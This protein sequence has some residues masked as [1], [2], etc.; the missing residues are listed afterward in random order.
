MNISDN[1][2][3]IPGIKRLISFLGIDKAIFYTIIGILW[4]SIAGVLSI[5]FIVNYL[6]LSEQGYWY[7]F[8]SLG[9]LGTF[10]ELG[11]TTI[12]TQFISHEYAH[13][14]E[15]KG[16]LFG[17]TK[18]LD[19]TISLI[20]FSFK[21]YLVITIVAFILLSIIGI[22]FLKSTTNNFLLLSSWVLYS[23]TGACF[24]LT[25]LFGAV[26]KGFNKVSTTQKIITITRFFSSIAIWTSLF[27]GLSLWAL[28]IGG[29]VNIIFSL[30]LFFLSSPNLWRQI[31]YT[32]VQGHYE[33]FKETIPLQWRYAISWASS[34]FIFQFIVPVTML[35]AGSDMAGK[36][37]LSL[38]IITAVQSIGSSWGMTKLPQLN[39]YVAK[40]NRKELDSLFKT[41]Q[42]QSLLAFAI[43]SLG[44]VIIFIFI[45]PIL[46]WENRIL[47]ISENV[48]LLL[49]EG[50]NLILFNWAF[51]LRSHKQEP[52]VR[53]SFLNA[54]LTAFGIF[55]AYYFF[56]STM[57]A[58][59]AFLGTQI[60]IMIP[61]WQ[62][63]TSKQKQY[64]NGK[65]GY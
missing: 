63:L 39:I 26:L 33:W 24:L 36:L 12:V 11:F 5:F 34:Y 18:N 52:Y 22:V 9:A 61:A 31:L 14:K 49:A 41:I 62:I 45:F 2:L 4:S 17:E 59:C 21:F 28:A 29:I 47:N 19:R 56:S 3:R 65:I 48:I 42:W 57:L 64:E 55:F 10:A 60:I 44:V 40:E 8:L 15:N 35:Y 7:T 54:I 1:I 25:S 37:G 43:G 20:K 53:I 27:S 6:T 16:E 30:V 23:F 58:L 13:L 32:P 38:S 50:A 51:Y 46:H